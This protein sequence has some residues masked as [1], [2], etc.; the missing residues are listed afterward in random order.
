MTHKMNGQDPAGNPIPPDQ[1]KTLIPALQAQREALAENGASPYQLGTLDKL[2]GI[3]KANDKMHDDAADAAA[4]H[5]ADLAASAAGKKKQAELDVE[6]NPTNQ[7][8]AARGA[9]L[10]TTDTTQAK[11]ALKPT[12][13]EWRQGVSADEKKKAELSENIAYN[14]SEVA[15]ILTRRPDL[16]GAVAGRA[17]TAQQLIGNND[18]DISAIGTHI[19]NMAMAN[20]GVHGFRS[21]EGVVSYEKQVL[22]NFRNGPAAVA[23]ALKAST[24]SVQTFIDNARPDN[25]KTHS[26]QGGA[27]RGM[28][29]QQ[30]GG[31]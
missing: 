28:L 16:I 31:Q 20:S 14:A 27:V 21:Q 3:Y 13:D 25:Y 8:A 24:G 18:P 17:T 22:N 11:N 2:I 1:L 6:N 7:A 5:K 15:K 29:Q 23:G 12:N 9:A 10:K 19:H 4:S 26:K 30:N